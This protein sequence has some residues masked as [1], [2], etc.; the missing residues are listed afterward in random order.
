MEHPAPS[1]RWLRDVLAALGGEGASARRISEGSDSLASFDVDDRLILRVALTVDGSAGLARERAAL[2]AIEPT[3]ELPVP[4]HHAHGRYDGLA[5]VAYPKLYGISG[6]DLLPPDDARPAMAEA[7]GGFLQTLHET[8]PPAGVPHG[9]PRVPWRGRLE[10]L[11]SLSNVIET[12]TPDLV[13]E[14]TL[15]YLR[16]EVD[17]PPGSDVQVL[18]HGDLKGE[19]IL[20]SSDLRG[21][22]GILDWN[23]AMLGDPAVD[24]A[25]TVIWLGPAFGRL[26]AASTGSDDPHLADRGIFLARVGM[27]WGLGR[28]LLGEEDWPLDLAVGQVRRAFGFE[29]EGRPA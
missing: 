22:T 2:A 14:E 23:D 1:A 10:E 16:G 27:L 29:T 6:R 13:N 20:L 26:V 25:G 18:C 15:P 9:H 3:V 21:I 7:L 4:R 8:K 11:P 5:W 28:S 17:P 12:E 19:H 24:V